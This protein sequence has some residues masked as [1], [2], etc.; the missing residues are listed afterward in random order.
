MSLN[1]SLRLPDDHLAVRCDADLFSFTGTAELAPLTGII[2]QERAAKAMTFGLRVKNKGYNIFIS[3]PTGTGR[4]SYA[5]SILTATAQE[6]KTPQD[7]CYVY[8]FKQPENPKAISLPAGQGKRFAEKI[9]ALLAD[10]RIAISK[11]LDSEE[12]EKQR[13]ALQERWQKESSAAFQELEEYAGSLGFLLRRTAQGIGT[14][15][16][17]DG[18]PL[19]AAEFEKLTGAEQKELENKSR[20]IQQKL[21]E[22]L[23]KNQQMDTLAREEMSRLEKDVAKQA[24]EPA[25]TR[26]KEYYRAF[27]RVL[28]Y[29]NQFFDDI[30]KHLEEFRP[31]EERPSPLPFM[32]PRESNEDFFIRYQVNL[33]VD[34]SGTKG[35]PVVFETNPTYYNV[36]GKIEGKAQMGAVI[37]NFTMIKNGSIHRANGGYLL[38]QAADLLR[39]PWAWP[40]LK[41]TLANE[42]AQ[43]ESIGEDMRTV[44]I[45]TLR[46]EPIPLSAKIVLIGSSEI[47]QLLSSYDEDFR[48]LFKIRADF[49]VTMPRSEEN[50]KSYATFIYDLCQRENLVHFTPSAV[51]AVVDY[52]SRLADDQEKLST[53]FNEI[54][55]ILYEASA[56]A[57]T[58]AATEVTDAHVDKA[59]VERIYRSNQPEELLSEMTERG[60]LLLDTSGEVIGQINGLSVYGTGD[61]AFGR[62]ARITASAYTGED[63]VINI[64]R[65][66]KLSGRIHDKGVLILAGY[67]GDKYAKEK[68]LSLTAGLAF[69]QSYG[70]VDGDSASCAELIALLSAL[71][72]VPLRQS[73]AITGSIN[74]KG[75][76]QPIGGV[77]EKIEGFFKTCLS[78]G[79]T[80]EQGVIIPKQNIKNL[81]LSREVRQAA[82]RGEFHIYAVA[83]VDEA[84]TLLTGGPAPAVH[85]KVKARL[86]KM[87]AESIRRKAGAEEAE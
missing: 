52:S 36:F 20:L 40:A 79:L 30:V 22:G 2:G 51:A 31:K 9:E 59:I 6:G 46:P 29:L 42:A 27:P 44:P 84:L 26:Q 64:E 54:V 63:G 47:Y 24:I 17:K 87:T 55:E 53:R 21:E 3:G 34:N 19:D 25:I 65:E 70:G 82:S 15:P 67:L 13:A 86:D 8:N 14:V 76:I 71:A 57:E 4:S 48:K 28:D 62:P 83:T 77:N 56:W 33:F 60:S 7:W 69:E 37:T 12:H 35:A 5:R 39:D 38:L 11:A 66:A 58:E 85:Q 75:E 45:T 1:D 74:Q 81:M 61:Y 23:R 78:R 10:C 72:E 41:R 73:L 80:G 50:M 16:L 68:P 43:V 49:A 18:E 32:L